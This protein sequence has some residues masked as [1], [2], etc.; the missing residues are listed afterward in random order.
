MI[1]PQ[2]LGVLSQDGVMRFINIQ[3]CKQLFE[4]GSYEDAITSA[5]ICPKGHHIAAVM[6]S[7]ALKIYDV[8]S[9]SPE[10]SKVNVL[11]LINNYVLFVVNGK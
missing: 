7:G 6:D 4:I 1:C 5:T 8:R 9:L 11:L 10:I 3:S 2:T